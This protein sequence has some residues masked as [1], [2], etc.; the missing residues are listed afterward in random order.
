MGANENPHYASPSDP[1]RRIV[2][3]QNG[4]SSLILANP[5]KHEVRDL[6]MHLEET[7]I[8]RFWSDE[9]CATSP[10]FTNVPRGVVAD[11]TGNIFI[12]PSL[13]IEILVPIE[14]DRPNS[15]HL[16]TLKGFSR[17]ALIAA[18]LRLK[19]PSVEEAV[20]CLTPFGRQRFYA[21]SLIGLQAK[22]RNFPLFVLELE[23]YALRTKG[24]ESRFASLALIALRGANWIV[25]SRQMDK[26]IAGFVRSHK[27]ERREWDD[28][29]SYGGSELAS[30]IADLLPR[31]TTGQR[32]QLDQGK[33]RYAVLCTNLRRIQDLSWE[34]AS[35][36]MKKS[37][38]EGQSFD[39]TAS[40]RHHWR[41]ICRRNCRKQK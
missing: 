11:R 23:R 4:Q 5:K 40:I 26:K 25:L 15:D 6:L 19:P 10:S 41:E 1:G 12:K 8:D 18:I 17:R 35:D 20:K 30:L 7:Y 37:P 24:F 34:L 3:N 39:P 27:A 21:F 2:F 13:L 9:L 28:P 33:T 38:T 36:L 31:G 29:L 14:S 32:L 16:T 22:I